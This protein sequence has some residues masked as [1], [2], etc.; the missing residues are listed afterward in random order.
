[1]RPSGV[2]LAAAFADGV[3]AQGLDVVD[4]GLASTDLVYF[5]AGHARRSRRHVHRLAQPRPVQRDE[6]L[7]RRCPSH[8][9][10]LRPP[11]HQADG[12]RGRARRT[13]APPAALESLDL[14]ARL[15]RPRAVL[16]RRVGAA[17]HSRSWP[18][19]PTAWAAS[20]S[21]PCSRACPVDLEVLY[22]ELDGTFP[23]HPAD[24]IQAE[25]LR[26]LQARVLE[27]GA[28][29]GL[30]F[31]G[32]A[33]RVFLVDELGSAAVRLHHHRHRRRRRAREAPRRHDP[34]QL[35][36]LQGRA[37]GRARARRHPGAHQGR[38]QLHQGGDGRDRAPPSA[39]STR[40][41]T[42]SATTTGPTPGRSPRCSCSS[43]SA[44]PA[45]RC[46]SCA[47]RSTATPRRARS[48][49]PSPTRPP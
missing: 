24:P 22:G 48:T 11:R 2:E 10:G 18:T 8:R 20:W 42:T 36:L 1:M 43:S 7:P 44:R 26:D 37:R 9:R 40:R 30:A 27:V 5:A 3:R 46:P 28:D 4:L 33:D 35:H 41:T 34:A 21:R 38:P 6:A 49:A 13:T 23:N 29:V 15:R 12:R 14:L 25:N 31:D 16:R 47:S 45:C 32:D 17:A 39:A 19:R